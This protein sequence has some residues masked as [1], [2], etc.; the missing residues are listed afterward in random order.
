VYKLFKNGKRAKAP[1]HVFEY[2]DPSSVGEY[3]DAK[4]KENFTE[5]IRRSKLLV[6]RSD[7]PQ[8]RPAS[9]SD[10][11]EKIKRQNRNIVFRKLINSLRDRP[12]LSAERIIGGLIYCKESDWKW[13]WAALEAGTSRYIVGLSPTFSSHGTAHEWMIEEI[14]KL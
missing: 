2:E 5:K 3:F 7:L 10:E 12:D 6:L 11:G 14:T 1:F 8:E 4:V 9:M 13:Q